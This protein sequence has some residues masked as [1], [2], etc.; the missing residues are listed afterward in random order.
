MFLLQII[1]KPAACSYPT[2][3]ILQEKNNLKD[4]DN[5]YHNK[6]SLKISENNEQI[7]LCTPSLAGIRTW[8]PDPDQNINT[9]L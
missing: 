3:Q 4:L 8:D 5:H 7:I 2:K 1:L 6:I 9:M